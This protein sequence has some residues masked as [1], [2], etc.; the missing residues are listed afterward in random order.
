M[1]RLLLSSLAVALLGFPMISSAA[2]L[3]F[4]PIDPVWRQ[5]RHWPANDFMQLFEDNS[6]WQ[7]VASFVHGFEISKRFVLEVPKLI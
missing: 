2:Q 1:R 6:P 3:W 7:K 5:I 4:T